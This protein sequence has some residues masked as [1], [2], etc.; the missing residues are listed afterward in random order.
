MCWCSRPGTSRCRT[1]KTPGCEPRP[2]RTHSRRSSFRRVCVV[3]LDEAGQVG[4]RDMRELMQALQPIRPALSSPATPGSMAAVAAGD[5][6]RWLGSTFRGRM[7][8]CCATFAGRMSNW[9]TR[10]KKRRFIQGYRAAAVKQ[11][12]AGKI[13]E[14]YDRLEKLGCIRE[15]PDED[16]AARP[17]GEYLT[18]LQRKTNRWSSRRRGTKFM[19]PTMPSARPCTWPG[20]WKKGELLWA[21]QSVGWTEAEKHDARYYEEGYGPCSS[22]RA[23]AVMR[24]AICARLPGPMSAASAS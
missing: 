24:K 10:W 19:R 6:L 3:I 11:A 13:A 18:A 12:A 14:S 17:R 15:L 4:V 9:L 2:W 23:M 21:Y 1:W 22:S 20:G 8:P 7:S 16:H 5:T